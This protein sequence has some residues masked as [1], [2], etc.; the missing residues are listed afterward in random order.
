MEDQVNMKRRE[1]DGRKD[2]NLRFRIWKGNGGL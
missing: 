1:E 2:W